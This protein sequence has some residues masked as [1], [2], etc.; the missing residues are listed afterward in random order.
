MIFLGTAVHRRQRELQEISMTNIKPMRSTKLLVFAAA[1]ACI[2][3]SMQILVALLGLITGGVINALADSLPYIRRP[4]LP[5]CPHCGQ[6]RPLVAW[7]G[8]S[9]RVARAWRC[10]EC[11]QPRGYRSV[12][13]ELASV[14]GALLIYW[15]DPSAASFWHGFLV[16]VVFLLI[17]VIDIEHRLILEVVTVPSMV[18]FGLIGIIDP[19]RGFGKTL[20]GGL[21]GFAFV[22]TLYFS[23][24]LF[25]RIMARVRGRELDE[26]VFGFGDVMLAGVIG[27]ILGW[28]GV[29]V[30]LFLAVLAAGLFSLIYLLVA[31]MLRRYTPFMAIPYGPFL[32]LGAA[33][34]Y[35]GGAEL[36]RSAY[37]G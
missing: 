22:L 36:L 32:I 10:P 15:R 7:L 25:A 33:F 35:Y 6:A 19:A 20:I 1:M 9:A 21:G 29:I 24:V 2:M 16:G 11:A 13:V 26:I 27:L 31:M 14:L 34:I 8:L 23:G 4:A 30:A 37:G 3:I 12:A 17:V 18:I 5:R 28:P